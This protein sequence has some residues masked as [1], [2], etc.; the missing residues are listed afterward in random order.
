MR[1]FDIFPFFDEVDV[2]EVRLHE[3]APVVDT[4]IICEARETYGG[5][6]RE[7]VLE[8]LLDTRFSAFKH[9]ISY[10]ILEKLEPPCVDRTSGRLREAYQRNMMALA[11]AAENPEPTDLIIFSDCDEIVSANAVK[12]V[13]AKGAPV[14]ISRFKQTSY[15]YNVNTVVDRGHDFASRARIGTYQQLQEVGT[16][17]AFRMANKNTEEFVI[18]GGGW[19][20]GYFGSIEKIKQKVAALSPFLSEYK[21]FGD[22]QLVSDI[23]KGRDLHH[24]RCELP[25]E[26]EYV[27]MDD[28]IA[29]CPAWLNAN[30]DQYMHF[31]QWGQVG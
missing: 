16:L 8:K 6:R 20:F 9:Q 27:P 2:L 18:E 15:Y 10:M 17:Y 25:A 4:F 23:R 28:A 13:V 1:V 22:A 3:L 5:Q 31:T 7:P 12:R 29:Q 26:F 30:I 24:R 11:L 19:H 21:L 14:S